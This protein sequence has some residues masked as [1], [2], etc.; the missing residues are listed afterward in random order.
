MWV[1]ARE[2]RENKTPFLSEAAKSF[3]LELHMDLGTPN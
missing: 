2:P 1:E 3:S